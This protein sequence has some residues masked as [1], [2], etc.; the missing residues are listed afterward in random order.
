MKGFAGLETDLFV[1]VTD[2]HQYSHYGSCH[3]R[4]C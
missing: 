4:A 3:P 1:E 2:S